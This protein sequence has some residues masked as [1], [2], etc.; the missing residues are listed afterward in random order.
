MLWHVILPKKRILIEA[1][2]YEECL[3]KFPNAKVIFPHLKFWA[4]ENERVVYLDA[5][6]AIIRHPAVSG[7]V[8]EVVPITPN[9]TRLDDIE[10]CPEPPSLAEALKIAREN[11]K[12]IQK[13]KEG[14]K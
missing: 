12:W 7:Y 11:R 4:D 14:T 5:D 9:G 10:I 8:Y 13:Y 6:F 3:R 2:N 1:E